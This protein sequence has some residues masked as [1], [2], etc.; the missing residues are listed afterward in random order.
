M[1]TKTTDRQQS[2]PWLAWLLFGISTAGV[3]ATFI[4]IATGCDDMIASGTPADRAANLLIL[5][6][7]YLFAT[8][9]M[10]ILYKHPGH[11]IGWLCLVIGALN[12]THPGEIYVGCNA[13]E[14]SATQ[15]VFWILYW[16]QPATVVALFVLLPTL[17]PDGHFLSPRWRTFTV[18]GCALYGL[19]ILVV[20][21]LP[22]PMM[23]NGMQDG[24]IITP[25]KSDGI[26]L[27]AGIV[28]PIAQH[29]RKPRLFHPRHE[30]NPLPGCA[31]S[32][33][34][35]RI[36]PTAQVVGLFLRRGLWHTDGLFRVDG[37]PILS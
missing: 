30:R 3:L 36:A 14:L 21:L 24:A 32:A 35:G 4:L 37:K 27:A 10:V 19:T 28:G 33:I 20:I 11:H 26:A 17:F 16:A 25:E 31:I 13:I 2:M 15:F 34:T 22:G 6:S 18:A 29:S 12:F 1:S 5:T 7:Q 23:W 9:G 8:I